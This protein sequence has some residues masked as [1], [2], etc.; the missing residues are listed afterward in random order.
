MGIDLDLLQQLLK[1]N[2]ARFLGYGRS[3]G[4][5]LSGF[6]PTPSPTPTATPTPI[7]T[8]T[9][10][11]KAPANPYLP[12]I[13][14]IWR[15]V[16]PT[17]VSNVMFGESSFNPR[18]IHINRPQEQGGGF[19]MV[20]PPNFSPQQWLELRRRYPS[21]DVGLMQIN[22]A[23]AM[24]QYLASKGLTYYDLLD[25]EKNLSVAYDLYAGRIPR[26]AP[27]WG[28]WAKAKEYGYVK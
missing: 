10:V 19:H 22:T 23:P 8:I 13:R 14:Q 3:E 6:T 17:M 2:L 18:V 27:G 24:S 25:P 28:N 5:A 26:T 21:I 11:P 9:P 7:P 12:L 20:V 15:N 1:E 16:N 4:G